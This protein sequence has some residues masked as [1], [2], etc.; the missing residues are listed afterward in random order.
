MTTL[1]DSVEEFIDSDSYKGDRYPTKKRSYDQWLYIAGHHAYTLEEI[2]GPAIFKI[3]YTGDINRRNSELQAGKTRTSFT[4]SII[5]AWPI[6]SARLFETEVK[7]YFKYFIHSEAYE[8]MRLG[9]RIVD[10]KEEFIWDL[11]LF[12]LVKLIRLLVLKFAI[13]NGFIGHT[14]DQFTRM[15]AFMRPPDSIDDGDREL[16]NFMGATYSVTVEDLVR[17]AST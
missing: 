2:K 16:A 7:R 4:G 3:G 9:N 5:Y 10:T 14:K 17:D 1:Y 15:Q 8:Y 6:P 13:V 11:K 12:T